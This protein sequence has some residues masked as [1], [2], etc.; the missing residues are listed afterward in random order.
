MVPGWTPISWGVREQVQLA[1]ADLME[2][3]AGWVFKQAL[4]PMLAHRRMVLAGS[5]RR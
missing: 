1:V 5:G 4:G 2:A 3:G